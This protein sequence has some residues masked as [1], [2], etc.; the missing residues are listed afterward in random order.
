[1]SS[2]HLYF[3]VIDSD[4]KC[5]VFVLFLKRKVLTSQIWWYMLK[6]P[7]LRRLRQE[8]QEFKTNLG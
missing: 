8:D 6:I 2:N 1:V 7:A 4:Y 5:E 3:F